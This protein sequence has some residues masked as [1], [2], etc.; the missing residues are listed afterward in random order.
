MMKIHPDKLSPDFAA[1]KKAWLDRL[2][3][4]IQVA[5]DRANVQSLQNLHLQVLITLK[6]YEE[7]D[8][9]ELR[10]G[11]LLLKKELS[12]LERVNQDTLE[13]PA[14]GF[15]NLKSYKKLEKVIAEP[16]KENAKGIKKEIKRIAKIHETLKMHVHSILARGGFGKS[17]KTRSVSRRK[18]KGPA[19]KDQYPLFSD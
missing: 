18:K 17:K 19:H 11:S 12:R 15:S 13:H 3:K 14:W 6:K 8:Y 2:W 4:K 1:N 7:L 9:S 10:S 5:Y 16:F